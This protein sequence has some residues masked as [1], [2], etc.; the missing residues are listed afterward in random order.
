MYEELAFMQCQ[1]SLFYVVITRRDFTFLSRSWTRVVHIIFLGFKKWASMNFIAPLTPVRPLNFRIILI[2][3][4]III[5]AII[6]I[7]VIRNGDTT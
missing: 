4:I 2:R 6:T 1:V 3:I 7:C 5:I